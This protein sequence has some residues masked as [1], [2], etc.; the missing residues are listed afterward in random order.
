[1]P[2]IVVGGCYSGQAIMWNLD[3]A[4]AEI[5]K[6]KLEKKSERNGDEDDDSLQPP[7]LPTAMS[8]IDTSHKRMVADLNWLPP[9]CQVNYKGQILAHEHLDENTYQFMTIAGDGQA[10][11]WDIRYVDISKGNLPHI[12]RPKSTNDRK[13]EVEDANVPWLPIFRMNV[14]RLEGVGELS[15][16]KL[17]SNLGSTEEMDRRSHI[18]ATSEEGDLVY[19]DWRAKRRGGGKDDDDDDAVNDV[20]EYVQ[21]MAKD[22]NRPCVALQQSPFFK[23][24]ILSVSD[25]TF[26]IWKL[27]QSK[28][29]FSSPDAS[30]YLTGGRWSPTRPGMLLISKVD[31]NVDVWDFTD[32]R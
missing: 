24:M 17:L 4:M 22:H 29:V 27:G 31:G 25:W 9:D 6:K 20:P 26:N 7:V 28:P 32:S 12:F 10:L 30:T 16:C 2:N 1:M 11:I 21:W 3:E 19:A 23:D 15:L 8:H 13:K 18:L 5:E 14:K